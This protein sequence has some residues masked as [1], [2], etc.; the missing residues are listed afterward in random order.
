MEGLA[1]REYH[2]PTTAV[3][4]RLASRR[5]LSRRSQNH[6]FLEPRSVVEIASRCRD[7]RSRR[8]T[9][10]RRNASFFVAATAAKQHEHGRARAH[11][12]THTSQVGVYAS[13]EFIADCVVVWIRGGIHCAAYRSTNTLRAAD[14]S[15]PH[16]RNLHGW[17]HQAASSDCPL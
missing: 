4:V 11:T 6:E 12:H 16:F 13:A 5:T 17:W 3:Y 1:A 8:G 2:P 9:R 14:Q 15:T 10:C 7:R